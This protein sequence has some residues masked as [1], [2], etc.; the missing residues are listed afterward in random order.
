MRG[1]R[2]ARLGRIVERLSTGELREAAAAARAVTLW[3]EAAGPGIARATAAESLR[4]GTL[5]IITRDAAWSSEIRLQ[6]PQLLKKYQQLLGR[7]V[8]RSIRCRVGSLPAPA[9]SQRQAGPPPAAPPASP[10]EEEEIAR[11][12]GDLEEEFRPVVERA[13]RADRARR[14]RLGSAGWGWCER[15]G[16]PSAPGLRLCAIC[17]DVECVPQPQFCPTPPYVDEENHPRSG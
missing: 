1:G 9:D 2:P 16:A 17:G 11:I 12:L 3:T 10:E 15:C 5:L 7:G 14:R 8:V 13:M 6:E 4:A